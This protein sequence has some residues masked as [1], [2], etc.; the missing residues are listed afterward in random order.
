[1]RSLLVAAVSIVLAACGSS[2]S[3]PSAPEGPDAGAGCDSAIHAHCTYASGFTAVIKPACIEFSGAAQADPSCP[4]PRNFLPHGQYATGPCPRST[5]D[6]SCVFR[7]TPAD[8]GACGG[9]ETIW[10]SSSQYPADAGIP[11]FPMCL[12]P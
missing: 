1:M 12:R 7:D 9:F 4:G 11:G 5:Y 8:A 10:W 3:G 6:A 2:S